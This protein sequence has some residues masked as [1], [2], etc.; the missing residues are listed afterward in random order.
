MGTSLQNLFLVDVTEVETRAR[1]D[2]L[3]MVI[4][5]SE[6]MGAPP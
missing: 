6:G 2:S 1:S 4:L 3:Q 5:V